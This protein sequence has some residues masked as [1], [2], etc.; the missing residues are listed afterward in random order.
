M[1]EVESY[2]R[3]PS[4]FMR[5]TGATAVLAATLGSSNS[6]GITSQNDQ[7]VLTYQQQT[8]S[9]VLVD[10]AYHVRLS[11]TTCTFGGRRYWFLCPASG[12]G[13][14]VAILYLGGSGIF[15]CR[16]CSLLAYKSQ[17]ET[18]L[19]RV[20][21]R[22]DKIRYRLGWVPGILNYPGGKPK[23]MHGQTFIKLCSDY[24]SIARVAFEE[25]SLR[26]GMLDKKLFDI[27][28]KLSPGR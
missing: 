24:D 4:T 18:R 3:A 16:H 9:G 26:L 2:R 15:A 28:N 6:L 13:R 12:C 22:A 17:R 7:L 10:R 23:G 27:S 20:I 8:P 1:R 14:R 11:S 5:G 25:I 19:G 21:R